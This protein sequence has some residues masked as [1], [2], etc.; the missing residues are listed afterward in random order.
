MERR[1]RGAALSVWLLGIVATI[2]ISLLGWCTYTTHV[3]AITLQADQIKDEAV[4]ESLLELKTIMPKIV[5]REFYERDQTRHS[6]EHNALDQ[7][8]SNVS[9]DLQELKIRIAE[10]NLRVME[11][12][13]KP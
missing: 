5:T 6:A 12:T 4:R 11:A 7:R 1:E 3:T 8:V 10:M 2:N 13:K 9:L